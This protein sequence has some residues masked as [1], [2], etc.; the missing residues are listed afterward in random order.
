V[1]YWLNW[2]PGGALRW[3]VIW[4]VSTSKIV[5]PSCVG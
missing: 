2:I 4:K 3:S 5:V 1:D